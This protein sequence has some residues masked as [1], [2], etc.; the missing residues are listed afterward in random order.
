MPR[1]SRLSG[2]HEK[3]SRGREKM[4]EALGKMF[5]GHEITSS[6]TRTP[7]RTN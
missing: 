4:S 5:E 6:T 1:S 3:T 2:W 7:L